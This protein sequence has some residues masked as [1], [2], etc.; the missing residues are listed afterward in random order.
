[1]KKT[2]LIVGDS[3][4]T[5]WTV[6]Y[7]GIGWVNML[8]DDFKITNISQAGVSEYKI[9]L[10]LKS[11]DV[12]KFDKV[13]ISHTSAYRIPIEEHPIHKNDILHNN[14]D[15]IFSDVKEHI[16]NPIMK[17]AYN[18]YSKIFYPDYFCFIN[19]LI[20]NEIQKLT[21]NSLNITFFDSF[22]DDSVHKLEEIFLENK[23]FI[24]H[25]SEIGNR[26]VHKKILELLK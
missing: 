10:Q 17:T 20:F 23:G 19:N 15:I 1:M 9:Y 8:E 13:L 25:L 18:F 2:L 12:T 16:D 11:V 24:N 4:S 3:F 21:P 7:N 22:Y 26:M 6:K 14:C 5:D